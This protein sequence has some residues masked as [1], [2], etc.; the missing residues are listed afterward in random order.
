MQFGNNQAE[1]LTREGLE[2][3]RQGRASEAR[4][5]FE[6]AARAERENARIWLLLAIA[7]RA[8]RMRRPRR[9]RSDRLLEIEPQSMRGLIMKGDC[10]ARAGEERVAVLLLQERA[11]ARGGGSRC[12]RPTSPSF[13]APRT[14]APAR[15]PACAR[16]EELAGGARA[17]A[18][19][20]QPAL[21]AVARH[22]GGAQAG[23][24]PG[25][26]AA[27]YFPELP[28]TQ[29]FDTADFDWAPA[30]EAATDAIR[31]ELWAVLAGGLEGFR[32]Y[33]QSEPNR[34]A[35]H[36]LLDKKDWSALFLCENGKRF[37]EAIARC[38]KTWEA[39][40]RRRSPG[41]SGRRRR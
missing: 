21:P 11:A 15:C 4:S 10:R 41:S 17:G 31:R 3:L 16:L 37:E 34:A 28:Q 25:A 2:A 7:C 22:H 13:A 35:P 5:R 30:V 8:Q 38:P 40:R 1:R 27:Y 12:R 29:F 9:R 19:E 26:H 14:A 33:I 36:R 39:V 20:A 6:E 24:F 32:P 23:L 18:R